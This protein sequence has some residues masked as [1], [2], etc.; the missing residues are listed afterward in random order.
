MVTYSLFFTQEVLLPAQT[1]VRFYIQSI[2]LMIQIAILW[3]RGSMDESWAAKKE[4]AVTPPFLWFEIKFAAF[5]FL[6]RT[7]GRSIFSPV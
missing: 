2:D 1:K 3:L 4:G 7:C 6:K 5:F